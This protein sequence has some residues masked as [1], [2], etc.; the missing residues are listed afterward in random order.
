MKTSIVWIILSTFLL[1]SCGSK[2]IPTDISKKT[3][4]IIETYTIG[5]AQTPISI[6]KSGRITASSTL[7][8]TAQ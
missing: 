2:V 5:Q 8:L 1:S 7:T 6:E 4:F 3:P